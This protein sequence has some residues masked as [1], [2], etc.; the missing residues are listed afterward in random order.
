MTKVYIARCIVKKNKKT[1]PKGAVIEGL[2][3]AEIQQGLARHWLEEVGSHDGSA[4]VKNGKPEK[5]NKKAGKKNRDADR[6]ALLDEAAAA[7]VAVS[8]EM[9]DAE[10]QRL[11]AEKKEQ[12]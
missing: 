6:K 1:Y 7:G 5:E 4:A 9:T 10:I 3:D 11:I 2:T 12:E 8:D